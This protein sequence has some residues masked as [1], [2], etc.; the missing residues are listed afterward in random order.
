MAVKKKKE[1]KKDL[2]VQPLTIK[3]DHGNPIAHYDRKMIETIKST[4]AKNATDEELYMFLA[5][6]NKYDLDVFLK[7]CWFI[8]YGNKDPQI[9]TSRDGFIK[10]AKRDA[11]FKQIQSQEVCEND[12][13]KLGHRI[14]EEGDLEISTFEHTFSAKDRGKVIGAW[15]SISYHSK[16]P[17]VV[18]VDYDE[19]KQPTNPLWKKNSA[20]MIKKV[21]EK[22]CCKLSANITGL[23]IPEEMPDYYQRES[24]KIVRVSDEA[25]M[26]KAEAEASRVIDVEI[27]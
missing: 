18:Y 4:V 17:L 15:C 8:K 19:Y 22:N 25:I 9:F 12:D 6:A 24:N 21:A 1:L 20:A 5:I 11:D 16:K 10:I 27:D 3:D 2:N 13:F 26:Q 7:E 14:N 23:Y